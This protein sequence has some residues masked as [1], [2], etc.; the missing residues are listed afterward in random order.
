MLGENDI[1]QLENLTDTIQTINIEIMFNKQKIWLLPRNLLTNLKYLPETLKVVDVPFENFQ[2][3]D[4]TTNVVYVELILINNLLTD[5]QF[6]QNVFRSLLN[7][8]ELE[9]RKNLITT[10]PNGIFKNQHVLSVLNLEEN[11]LNVLTLNSFEG[12]GSLT[13]LKL[14]NNNLT[15][16][17]ADIFFQLKSLQNLYL[18]HNLLFQFPERIFNSMPAIQRLDLGHNQLVNITDANLQGATFK[19]LYLNDNHLEY[20]PE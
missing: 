6:N 11:Q 5:T 20:I 18:Q 8:R 7:L 2:Q 10:I 16:L 15:T 19:Y 13:D 14:N 12:L 4:F 1:S 9:I 3:S 17:S